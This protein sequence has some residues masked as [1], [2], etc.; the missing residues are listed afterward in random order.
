MHFHV[1]R[2][3]YSR[4]RVNLKYAASGCYKSHSRTVVRQCFKDDD[5]SQWGKWKIRPLATPKLLNRSS[6]KVAYVIRAIFL[7]SLVINDIDEGIA[8]RLLKFA[9]D[10]KIVGTISSDLETEQLR[11]DLK[12]NY[13]IGL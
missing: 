7:Y 9:D 2:H 13:V 4:W 10:T 12:Q 5:A 1:S 6:P 11:L 3:S 8:N